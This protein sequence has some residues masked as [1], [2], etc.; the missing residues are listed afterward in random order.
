M[1]GGKGWTFVRAVVFVVAVG[2]GLTGAAL[3]MINGSGAWRFVT[4]AGWDGEPSW[5]FFGLRLTLID[6]SWLCLAVAIVLAVIYFLITFSTHAWHAGRNTPFATMPRT[7]AREV[8]SVLR[9]TKVSDAEARF[10]ST[11]LNRP[12]RVFERISESVEPSTRSTLI[13]TTY[14]AAFP[15]H[16]D[17]GSLMLPLFLARRGVIED[18]LRLHSAGGRRLSSLQHQTA[19]AYVA[20]VIART[21]RL[22]GMTAHNAYRRADPHNSSLEDRVIEYLIRPENP[23][24]LA[25]GPRSRVFAELVNISGDILRLPGNEPLLYDVVRML[26]R[27]YSGHPIVVSVQPLE[28]MSTPLGSTARVLVERRVVMPGRLIGRGEVWSI[29]R[30]RP[31]ESGAK[32]KWIYRF[33][34]AMR[35]GSRGLLDAARLDFGAPPNEIAYPLSTAWRARSY[36]LSF[37]GPEGTFMAK[38]ELRD[39]QGITVDI[40][41]I[42]HTEFQWS[43]SLGQ[44]HTHLYFR[45]GA[46][47]HSG[48]MYAA[49]Y[50]ERP[51]GSMWLAFIA[52]VSALVVALI[53]GIR[54]VHAAVIG[55][56]VGAADAAGL[57]TLLF[58]LPLG[59]VVTS[60]LLSG[61]SLYGHVLASRLATLS[62]GLVTGVALILSQLTDEL[63]AGLLSRLWIGII[64]V[65]GILAASCLGS[66]VMRT[67]LSQR[68]V[69]S[70]PRAWEGP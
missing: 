20:A 22:S 37:K 45:N 48:L 13:R 55:A 61:R 12:S 30:G 29:L 28:L 1:A 58:T 31:K 36:H 19:I 17:I 43:P 67:R 18:G 7:H 39:R 9:R 3:M 44:R 16:R 63:P 21:I 60:L 15:K 23:M 8:R 50:F 34:T 51:M 62:I 27:L 46:E 69:G 10:F 64:V 11:A 25:D 2:V 5:G 54:A 41:A 56:D 49:T 24:D 32:P 66:M 65:L 38:Q 35:R 42:D 40:A 57:F 14:V 59:T 47:F 4:L 53:V 52:A 70:V 26:F 68:F 6:A 33:S